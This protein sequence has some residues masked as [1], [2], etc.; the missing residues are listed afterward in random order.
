MN[1]I[2]KRIEELESMKIVLLEEIDSK[3]QSLKELKD[4]IKSDE[5]RVNE[6][7]G[8]IEELALLNDENN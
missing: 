1:T 8:A 4:E 5:V 2:T 3:K 7:N 6:I